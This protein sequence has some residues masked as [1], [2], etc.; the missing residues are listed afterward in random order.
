MTLRL[1][2]LRVDTLNSGHTRL[3]ASATLPACH[4]PQRCV[5]SLSIPAQ[6]LRYRMTLDGVALTGIPTDFSSY[7][8]ARTRSDIPITAHIDYWTVE[9]R[10]AVSLPLDITFDGPF[11]AE[12][13]DWLFALSGEAKDTWQA[14]HI[15]SPALPIFPLSQHSGPPPIAKHIC[16][17][18]CLSMA[19]RHYGV[20]APLEE[21]A[22]YCHNKTHNM[23]GIWPQSLWAAAQ[24]GLTGSIRS[25]GGWQDVTVTLQQGIPIAASIAYENGE[26]PDAGVSSTKGHFVLIV[27]L[28]DTEVITLDPAHASPRVSAYPLAAFTKAWQGHGG[29]G[30]LWW[31]V[32]R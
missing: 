15:P 19:L 4:K 14:S 25:F 11:D 22:A 5:P 30:I 10:A 1:S 6:S 9:V 2:A 13:S 18:T 26:L 17:P 20:R 7:I 32:R 16:L 31:P 12:C 8:P 3:S 24:Y 29:I 21:V 23:Y 27:G 28:S